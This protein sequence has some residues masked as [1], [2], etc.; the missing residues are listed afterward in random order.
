MASNNSSL[1]KDSQ[2]LTKTKGTIWKPLIAV[3][4]LSVFSFTA[5]Q[6]LPYVIIAVS[7]SG[8]IAAV[9][10]A[11]F[12]VSVVVALASVAYLIKLAVSR[13]GDEKK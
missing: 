5:G 13:A 9:P 3:S 12:A 8:A 2:E 7:G 10:L 6:Y 11:I 4:L 1:L